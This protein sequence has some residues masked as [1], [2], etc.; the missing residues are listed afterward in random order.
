VSSISHKLGSIHFD[1]LQMERGYSGWKAQYQSRLAQVL[2]TRELARRS[3]GQGWPIMAVA[4]HPDFARKG[5]IANALSSMT[6]FNLLHKRLGP[7]YS[8]EAEQGALPILYAAVSPD[9]QAGGLYGP[10][11][12]GLGFSEVSGGPTTYPNEAESEM[13]QLLWERSEELT[14][15]KWP[16][17]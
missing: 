1:D 2:F 3:R 15:V 7:H 14:G 13:A 6:L 16:R 12:E 5:I 4:A 9:V 11:G 8:H 10:T 17:G